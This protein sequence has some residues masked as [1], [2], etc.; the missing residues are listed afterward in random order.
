VQRLGILVALAACG[1]T[2][3]H[4][5]DQQ[6][7]AAQ[8]SDSA[9]VPPASRVYAHSGNTLYQIDTQTLAPLQ[10]GAMSGLGTQSL[11]DL[12]IDNLAAG[13]AVGPD[14]NLGGPHESQVLAE[15]VWRLG[16]RIGE[17][18]LR[19]RGLSPVPGNPSLNPAQVTIN[20]ARTAITCKAVLPNGG[21]LKT[22]ANHV[23]EGFELSTDGGTTWT[24][25]GFTAAITAADTV[26]L[27]KTAGAWPAGVK[28]TYLRGGPFSYGTAEDVGK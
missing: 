10:V 4:D 20:P 14:A 8:S 15:G 23:V 27:T 18:Y 11:T 13:T 17:T 5:P 9:I 25:A 1:P 19:A 28:V 26:V 21:A 3:R 7:D 12:A 24:R 6:P 22:Q 16:Y 2:G